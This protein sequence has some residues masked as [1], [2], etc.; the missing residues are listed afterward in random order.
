MTHHHEHTERHGDHHDVTHNSDAQNRENQNHAGHAHPGDHWD[1]LPEAFAKHLEVESR[2]AAP[3]RNSIIEQVAQVLPSAPSLIIDVGSGTG[4]DT[5]A[6]AERFLTARVHALDVSAELLEHVR[7]NARRAGVTDRVT[8]HTADLNTDWPED[9]GGV[10]VVWASLSMH[11]LEDPEA[12]LRRALQALRPGGVLVMTELTGQSSYLP[13]DLG[14]GVEGLADSIA[15]ALPNHYVR[16]ASHWS[17]ALDQA[18]FNNIVRVEYEFE[19]SSTT[20]DGVTYLEQRLGS[21]RERLVGLVSDGDRTAI[22]VVVE[23]LSEGSSQVGL[24]SP[25]SVW[26]A[27]RPAPG[28]ALSRITR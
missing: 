2:L 18:G 25:R 19:A 6:L 10:D 27:R 4:A 3:I 17:R 1:D 13:T 20:P 26:I 9:S 7:S 21:L 14:T 16:D 8:C 22:D 15:Q 23:A 24:A 11:H 12:T 5:I 28:G